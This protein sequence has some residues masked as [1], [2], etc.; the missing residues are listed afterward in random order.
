MPV[1]P[2][3]RWPWCLARA[4]ALSPCRVRPGL[5]AASIPGRSPCRFPPLDPRSRGWHPAPPVPGGGGGCRLAA[6]PRV[7]R[8]GG[9]GG[10]WG[11]AGGRGGR[12]AAP[13][14]R[15]AAV[16]C[17]DLPPWGGVGVP[18]RLVPPLAGPGV[19]EGEGGR[20]GLKGSWGG[21]EGFGGLTGRAALWPHSWARPCRTRPTPRGAAAKPPRGRR[22]R[23]MP[24]RG[25]RSL[26]GGA[27]GAVAP[28]LGLAEPRT[29]QHTPVGWRPAPQLPL[30]ARPWAG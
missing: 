1:L 9:L 29:T 16:G 11:V 30:R 4:L 26:R 28:L 15:R 12:V 23:A 22:S 13:R 27:V 21:R 7:G 3:C 19:G 20:G 10:G 5:S 14:R 6:V 8:G 2:C 18:A 24:E 17:A 25:R